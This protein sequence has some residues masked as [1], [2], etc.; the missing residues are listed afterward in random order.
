MWGS[1]Q[2]RSR[3]DAPIPKMCVS[4]MPHLLEDQRQRNENEKLTGRIPDSTIAIDKW[5]LIRWFV[6]DNAVF[7]HR[8][9]VSGL[10]EKKQAYFFAMEST[11]AASPFLRCV[12]GG[13]DPGANTARCGHSYS[14]SASASVPISQLPIVCQ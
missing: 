8:Y 1:V 9:G 14:V 3:T 13:I 4:A 12:G 2:L 7:G 5:E 11:S 10:G 6:C